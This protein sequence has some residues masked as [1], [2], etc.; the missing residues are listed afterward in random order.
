MISEL[1]DSGYRWNKTSFSLFLFYESIL[2]FIQGTLRAQST[3][4]KKTLVL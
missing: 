3:E 4:H 2:N 1:S